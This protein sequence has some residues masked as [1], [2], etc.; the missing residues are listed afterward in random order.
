MN[1]IEEK[2]S[3][4]AHGHSKYSDGLN[5]PSAIIAA[6]LARNLDIIGLS[7]H[8]TV[9]GLPAFLA[10]ADAANANGHKILAVPSIEVSTKEGHVLVAVP[11]RD[12]A[13][14]LLTTYKSHGPAP[15]ALDLIEKSVEAYDAICILVHPNFKHI[16]SLQYGVIDFIARTCSNE[17]IDHLGIEMHNWMTM[18]FLNEYKH[19]TYATNH[20][21]NEW[22]FAEFSGT[23]YHRSTDVGRAATGVALTELTPEAL[24]TA[25]RERKTSVAQKGEQSLGELAVNISLSVILH[26]SSKAKL[27][28]KS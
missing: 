19:N 26:L 12:K 27:A 2:F 6:A 8:D 25:V 22:G 23:D 17:A 14:N 11:D 16:S 5:G 24:I 4:D 13:E 3:Y 28:L 20:F 21:N 1:K 18:V 9:A 7:D 15:H 10:A